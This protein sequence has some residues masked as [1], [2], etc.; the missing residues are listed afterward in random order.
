MSTNSQAVAEVRAMRAEVAAYR[1]E[2]Q[3]QRAESTAHFD[4]MVRAIDGLETDMAAVMRRL[5]G[6]DT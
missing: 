6:E 3:T 1:A 4:R 5:F 2:T